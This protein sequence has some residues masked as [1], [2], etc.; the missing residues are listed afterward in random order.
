MHGRDMWYT[1]TRLRERRLTVRLLKL[2]RALGFEFLV[3]HARWFR[4]FW[5]QY[6]SFVIRGKVMEFEFEVVK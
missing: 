4:R 5:E 3:N 6:L 2:W 1:R